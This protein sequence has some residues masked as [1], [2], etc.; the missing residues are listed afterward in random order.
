MTQYDPAN[1]KS[2]F[3]YREKLEE[4]RVFPPFFKSTIFPLFMKLHWEGVT[5]DDRVGVICLV[6]IV[7]V[8]N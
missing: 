5:P 3:F 2:V 7:V 1:R 6:F 8:T 4:A